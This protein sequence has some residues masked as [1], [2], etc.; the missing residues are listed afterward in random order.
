MKNKRKRL[1]RAFT[2]ICQKKPFMLFREDIK[3]MYR[4]DKN[5]KMWHQTDFISRYS[6]I[7]IEEQ[8]YIDIF[9]NNME[10]FP[11]QNN[12]RV[13]IIDIIKCE[14]WIKERSVG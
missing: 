14:K 13:N 12:I 10:L 8:V 9:E 11:T 4:Y 3:Y 2:L 6:G 7:A 5:T 1:V